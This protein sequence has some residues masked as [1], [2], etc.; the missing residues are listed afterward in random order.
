MLSVA[1]AGT[2]SDANPIGRA[3][4][5]LHAELCTVHP[6]LLRV[7]TPRRLRGGFCSLHRSL[8]GC[9]CRCLIFGEDAQHAEHHGNARVKLN[10]ESKRLGHICTTEPHRPATA[11][12]H[13]GQTHWRAPRRAQMRARTHRLLAYPAPHDALGDGLADIPAH[14]ALLRMRACMRACVPA[15]VRV[16]ARA[17]DLMRARVRSRVRGY[18]RSASSRP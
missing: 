15:V 3:R 10:P 16:R 9:L 8:S 5:M 6:G 7:A 18:T 13:Q 4:C 12:P 2:H 14:N 1:V 11:A 17:R